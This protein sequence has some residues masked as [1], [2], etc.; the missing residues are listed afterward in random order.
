MSTATMASTATPTDE[1]IQRDVLAELKWEP[2]VQPNEIGVAVKDGVVTLTGWVDSY[3]KRW[4]AEEAAHRVRGVKAVANDIE[5]RLPVLG[6]AHRRRHR[7]GGGARAGVGRHRAHRQ[8]R[9]HRVQGLGDA[10]GRSGVAVPEAGR[11]AGRAPAV[12]RP[13]RDQPHHASSRASAPSELKEK[14]EQALVRSAQTDAQRI[15][16]E[17]QGQQGH[18]ERDR[19]APG[20]SGKRR[21]GRRGRRR[22]S[23]R[24]RTGSRFRPE[25][26]GEGPWRHERHWTLAR[27]AALAARDGAPVRR[28]HAG[29]ALAAHRRVSPDQPH[30]RRHRASPSR[31]CARAPIERAST[32]SVA[33]RGGDDPRRATRRS[34]R[35]RGAIS[36]ARAAARRV[37]TDRQRG[38]PSRSRA[39]PGDASPTASSGC[40]SPALPKRRR[41]R[42]RSRTDG[43]GETAWRP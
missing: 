34:R 30:A 16:V 14:I 4:A 32:I 1:Q 19:C 6:R 35:G 18:P 26:R 22:G 29:V 42:S 9:R 17:V 23:P 3:T 25:G 5:V 10:Q 38:R 20:P 41:R 33:R 36:P 27:D 39:D 8:A 2:R 28:L 13:R 37:H 15:T 21:S 12:G 40:S 43:Q 11:R 31:R 7:C 24:W